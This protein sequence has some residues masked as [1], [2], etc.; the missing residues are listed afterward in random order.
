MLLMVAMVAPIRSSEAQMTTGTTRSISFIGLSP[1]FFH[2]PWEKAQ[3]F[4]WGGKKVKICIYLKFG[5]DW[6]LW[7]ASCAG[8]STASA[9]AAPPGSDW[10]AQGCQVFANTF[11]YLN[12][13]FFIQTSLLCQ[14]DCK[15][16]TDKRQLDASSVVIFTKILQHIYSHFFS[17]E[18]WF[19]VAF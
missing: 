15:H 17:E 3:L 7:V 19:M 4:V 16:V 12:M 2:W 11:W 1:S 9:P 10:L 6:R 13:H 18:P 5:A 14:F 8:A